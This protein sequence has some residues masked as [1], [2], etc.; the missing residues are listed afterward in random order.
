MYVRCLAHV[1]IS[2]TTRILYYMWIF[3]STIYF[4]RASVHC[5]Y[6]PEK[7]SCGTT[8]W[9]PLISV[10]IVGNVS[11]GTLIFDT[12]RIEAKEE[13]GDEKRKKLKRMIIIV[14]TKMKN[15]EKK[16]T[17][18]KKENEVRINCSSS[19]CWGPSP[20]FFSLCH[21][22]VTHNNHESKWNEFQ[23]VFV[24]KM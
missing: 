12:I 2:L 15:K 1:N 3:F 22:T 23:T 10:E 24:C 5:T 16:K 8:P 21:Q 20:S 11:Q 14:F 9:F 19:S 4:N 6:Q 18:E 13:D 7:H 17:G